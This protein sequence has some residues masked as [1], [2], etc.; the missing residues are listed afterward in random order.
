MNAKVIIIILLHAFVGWLLCGAIMWIGMAVTSML[1]A[2]IAH[3]IGAPV[4]FS[5]VSLLYFRKFNYTT[6][7]QTALIFT[8]FVITVDFFLVALVI[9]RSLEMFTVPLGTWIPFALI[10]ISTYVTGT[11]TL[12]SQQHTAVTS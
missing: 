5:A 9:N 6:P 1:N 11:Y 3:A 12:N 10:F 8:G 4:I 2:Q 7:L